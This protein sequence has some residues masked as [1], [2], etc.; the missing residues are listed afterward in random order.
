[1]YSMLN[2]VAIMTGSAVRYPNWRY[3]SIR[4][5]PTQDIRQPLFGCKEPGFGNTILEAAPKWLDFGER[6]ERSNGSVRW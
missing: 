3:L 5:E 1:M 6:Y 4:P 2:F